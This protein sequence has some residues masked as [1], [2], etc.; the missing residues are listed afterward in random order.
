MII[1]SSGDADTVKNLGF[2]TGFSNK[3]D[4]GTSLKNMNFANKPQGGRYEFEINGVPIKGLTDN[5]TL[6]DVISAINNSGAGVKVSYS[7][8]ADKFIME[9]ASTGAISNITMKQTY[10]TL[11]TSMFGVEAAGVQSSL[12]QRS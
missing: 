12:F 8:A 6:S 5:S 10:G 4:Y 2:G 7:S 9:S 11:L 3:L 1:Q